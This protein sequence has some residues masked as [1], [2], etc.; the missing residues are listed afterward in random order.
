MNREGNIYVLPGLGAD[1]SMYGSEWHHIEGCRFLDWP[2]YRGETSIA[3][4]AQRIVDEAGIVDG[5]TVIGSSLG[6]MVACEIARI[7]EVKL[8]ILVGSAV[9]PSE[10]N[11]ALRLLDRVG[12]MVPLRLLQRLARCFSSPVARMFSSSDP[13]FIRGMSRA[14]FL[15][16]GWYEPSVRLLRIH[17]SRDH[18]IVPPADADLYL[19]GG[20]L[21]P[22]THA[23]ECVDFISASI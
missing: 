8:L 14:I 11:R 7:R 19:D 9:S 17:G 16:E 2:A 18:V 3:G 4:M 20:H 23:K 6:G 15:W 21:I 22:M 5:S 12:G 1:S 13:D 10:V